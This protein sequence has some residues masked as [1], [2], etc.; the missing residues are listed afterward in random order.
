MFIGE[1]LDALVNGTGLS[2]AE[3]ITHEELSR[4]YLE[5]LRMQHSMGESGPLNISTKIDMLRRLG[6]SAPRR[7]AVQTEINWREV[8]K[9]LRVAVTL[10]ASKPDKKLLGTFLYQIELGLLA[11]ELDGSISGPDEFPKDRV[12]PAFDAPPKPVAAAIPQP[13]TNG[14]VVAPEVE[15][16]PQPTAGPELSKAIDRADPEGRIPVPQMEQDWSEVD[17]GQTV[18]YRYRNGWKAAEFIDIGPAD[19]HVSIQF[20]GKVIV[21]KETHVSMKPPL[22]KPIKAKRQKAT[23]K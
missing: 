15:D 23:S 5:C 3:V 11:V 9:G 6:M 7:A 17:A 19:G 14:Q 20:D 12:E 4:E 22:P 13:S 18:S 8:K 10:D 2:E 21:A 16:E 1:D